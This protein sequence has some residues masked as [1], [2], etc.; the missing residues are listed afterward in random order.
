MK[1]LLRV[2]HFKIYENTQKEKKYRNLHKDDFDN[3]YDE[4]RNDEKISGCQE[5]LKLLNEIEA[6]IYLRLK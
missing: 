1:G 4:V 6:E 5:T 2:I 3:A